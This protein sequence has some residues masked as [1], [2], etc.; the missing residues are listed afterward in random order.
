MTAREKTGAFRAACVQLRSSDD[1]A[2][3]VRATSE[4]IR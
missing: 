3:N 2:E 1:V 4:L